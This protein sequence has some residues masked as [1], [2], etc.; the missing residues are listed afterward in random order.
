MFLKFLKYIRNIFIN[1]KNLHFKYEYLKFGDIIT[2]DYMANDEDCSQPEY[3]DV[4][5]KFLRIVEYKS[6]GGIDKR[7]K[8]EI[9]LIDKISYYSTHHLGEYFKPGEIIDFIR[10]ESIKTLNGKTL[11]E[12]ENNIS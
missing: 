11:K 9:E 12:Y 6:H 5:A 10:I 4:R 8:L 2:F 3:K 7:I 1:S